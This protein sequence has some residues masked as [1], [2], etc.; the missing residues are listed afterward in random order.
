MATVTTVVVLAAGMGVLGQGVAFA[1]K[2]ITVCASGCMYSSVSDAVDNAPSGATIQIGPGTYRGGIDIV[3]KK[4]TLQG[5]GP[6]T[7]MITANYGSVVSVVNIN[8]SSK[9]ELRNLMVVGGTAPENPGPGGGGIYNQGQLD[10]YN[11]R[12]QD[13][14]AD[15]G[16]G[17][18]NKGTLSM[19]FGGFGN[20]IAWA[21]GGLYNA[22]GATATLTDVGVSR[23][24][25]SY[26]G[27]IYNKGTLKVLSQASTSSGNQVRENIAGMNGGGIYNSGTVQITRGNVIGN[28][29]ESHEGGGIYND[30]AGSVTLIQT[31][32][33][34]NKAT[35]GAGI[36]NNGSLKLQG[37][38]VHNN[39]ARLSGGGLFTTTAVNLSRAGISQ[40]TAL[41]GADVYYSKDACPSSCPEGTGIQVWMYP[42]F[43][44]ASVEGWG[45][46]GS[47]VT[48]EVDN[49]SDG[50]VDY[51]AKM[52]TN[53][54]G[55]V[56]FD[57]DGQFNLSEGD[58]VRLMS[59]GGP[60]VQETIV[61]HLTLTT[62]DPNTDIIAGTAPPNTEVLVFLGQSVGIPPFDVYSDG[63]GL[64]SF[65]VAQH[66]YDLTAGMT[67]NVFISDWLGGGTG[68]GWN[69]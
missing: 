20:N 40:N 16:G 57:A 17:I 62:L 51:A 5:A 54:N 9:V 14:W 56:S 8:S 2:T 3:D 28:M 59:D 68:I 27:G 35:F 13:N 39:A 4:L 48:L 55:P 44:P 33:N 58:T 26:G 7:T 23:N 10:L 65:N 1:A 69:T 45:W 60:T 50:T 6:L 25:A 66:G 31:S 29:A 22:A 43:T 18:Y 42:N 64:W 49:G 52:P 15:Y 21:G 36:F 67:G 11:V 19:R 41:A 34:S 32:V 53:P 63:N 12:V 46:L 38:G 47:D 24:S 37:T 30:S 61:R